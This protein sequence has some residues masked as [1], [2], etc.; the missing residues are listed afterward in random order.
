M[1]TGRRRLLVALAAAAVALP[2]RALAPVEKARIDQLIQYVASRK[3]V[4]FVRNGTAYSSA[5]AAK[6]LR[7]KLDKMGEH[8]T[9]ARDFIEQIAS[10]S[11]TTGQPYLIRFADGR[12]EPSARF[13][14]EELRRID[15]GQ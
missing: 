9:S 3:D 10:K 7:G 14:G 4:K 6:F 8:V 2:A 11:S 5:D 12:T 1:K 13:L 15:G